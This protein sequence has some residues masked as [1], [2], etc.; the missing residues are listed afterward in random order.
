MRNIQWIYPDL[1]LTRAPGY[2]E[3]HTRSMAF[4]CWETPPPRH[5]LHGRDR[6]AESSGMG[7][8]HAGSQ[9]TC[10]D[11]SRLSDVIKLFAEA[12]PT[13]ELREAIVLTRGHL[14]CT[15]V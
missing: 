2:R 4:V 11:G 12:A 9:A 10:M 15:C 13:C 5:T 3:T 7:S 1:K 14:L 6:T 8:V